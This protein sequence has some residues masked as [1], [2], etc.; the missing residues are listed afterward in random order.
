MVNACFA[1]LGPAETTG[2]VEHRDVNGPYHRIHQ[3]HADLLMLDVGIVQSD[4]DFHLV[5]DAE[6]VL[7]H[8]QSG[9]LKHTHTHT[10]SRP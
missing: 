10:R 2:M 9:A 6:G 1:S 7:L 5:K 3:S 4:G 8:F